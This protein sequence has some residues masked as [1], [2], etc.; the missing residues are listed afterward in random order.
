MQWLPGGVSLDDLPAIWDE[1]RLRL[2]EG[3]EHAQGRA[4]PAAFHEAVEEVGP[5]PEPR[6][7]HDAQLAS[8]GVQGDDLHGG[9]RVGLEHLG[10]ERVEDR[11]QRALRREVSRGSRDGRDPSLPVPLTGVRALSARVVSHD[12]RLPPPRIIPNGFG[13]PWPARWP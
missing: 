7:P 5:V 13:W 1:H 9:E 6:R 2:L 10:R 8:G 12:R 3:V 11:G 4:A